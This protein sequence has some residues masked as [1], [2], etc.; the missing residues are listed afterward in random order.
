[1]GGIY[2]RDLSG[3][4]VVA[5]EEMRPHHVESTVFYHEA[6]HFTLD[7]ICLH[8]PNVSRFHMETGWQRWHIIGCYITPGDVSTIEDIVAAIIRCPR[9]ARLLVTGD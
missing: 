8:V 3:Y 1:M 5:T 2:T 4:W 7:V 6:G 9:G